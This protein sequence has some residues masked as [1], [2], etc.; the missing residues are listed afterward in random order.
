MP[1]WLTIGVNE[2]VVWVARGLALLVLAGFGFLAAAVWGP[3]VWEHFS[4]PQ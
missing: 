1:Q 4:L 2:F 3:S